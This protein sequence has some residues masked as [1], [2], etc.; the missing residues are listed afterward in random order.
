MKKILLNLALVVSTACTIAQTPKKTEGTAENWY[1]SF[2]ANKQ[3]GYIH[4]LYENRENENLL[5]AS[6][7]IALTRGSTTAEVTVES[8]YAEDSKTGQLTS[9]RSVMKM[10]NQATINQFINGSDSITLTQEMG[11]KK[12]TR[13]L[14]AK[15]K[16]YGPHWIKQNSIS[17]LQKIGDA[18]QFKTYSADFGLYLSGSRSVVGNERVDDQDLLVVEEAFVEMP[19]KRKLWVTSDFEIVKMLDVTPFWADGIGSH[20]A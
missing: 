1:A 14:L 4:E 6:N 8:I 7:R 2:M 9:I 18:F 12:Y 20:H 13:K 17:R 10:S 15:E 11:G 16:V 19:V 3:I 5:T